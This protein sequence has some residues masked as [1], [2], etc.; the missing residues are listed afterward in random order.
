MPCTEMHPAAESTRLSI[1]SARMSLPMAS[2]LQMSEDEVMDTSDGANISLMG[3]VRS[4]SD[5]DTHSDSGNDSHSDVDSGDSSD[6]ASDSDS[7]SDSGSDSHSDNGS[8][9]HSDSGSDS[10]D[11]SDSESGSGSDSG[12]E[13]DKTHVSQT[14][15]VLLIVYI[16]GYIY[17]Q[18]VVSAS[19][20]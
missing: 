18:R 7:G 1:T 16:S 14:F 13:S 2:S 6:S 4:D 9:S 5:C 11:S 10:G 3:D 20:R 15:F 17:C 12:S 19:Y 8:D